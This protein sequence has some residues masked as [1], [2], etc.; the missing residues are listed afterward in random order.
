M[1]HPP[2]SA[3]AGLGLTL[4]DATL[5]GG[6]VIPVVGNVLSGLTA[7]YDGYQLVKAYKRCWNSPN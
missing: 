7:L 3:A 1:A 4:A 5:A 6:K 2:V